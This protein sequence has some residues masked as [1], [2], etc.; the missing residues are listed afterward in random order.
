M[1][2]FILLMVTLVLLL[3]W[4]LNQ[5]CKGLGKDDNEDDDDET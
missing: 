1:V 5:T 4:G 2:T 3:R